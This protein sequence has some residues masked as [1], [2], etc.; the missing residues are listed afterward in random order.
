MAG[1][2]HRIGK[3]LIDV[4]RVFGTEEACVTYLETARWPEGVRCLQCEYA[5]ISK[6]IRKGREKRN[7]DGQL[8]KTT[9]DRILYQCLNP[10]CKY[11]FSV[12]T[13]TIFNDTHLPL[14]KWFLAVGLMCIAKK[15]LSAKQM[16]RDLGVS[17]KT[18]WYLC[19]RIRK[20]MDEGDE[21][22]LTGTVE[23]D[24]TYIGGKYDKRRKRGPY[25][26]QPVVG[27]I[28]RGKGGKCSTVRTF[29][30]PT[31]SAQGIDWRC[32]QPRVARC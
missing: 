26:K 25:E 29:P 20:A 31:N 28:E 12:T 2:T 32:Y 1:K 5:N 15:G 9:H 27:L 13:G 19:H 18:A 11:Q 8:V 16:Q 7:E 10:L 23:V 30:I 6:F 24:E 22:L 4:T 14:N 21:G 3:S 17:Y